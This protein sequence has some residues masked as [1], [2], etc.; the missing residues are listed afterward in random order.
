[1]TSGVLMLPTVE[2][3]EAASA[4]FGILAAY[5]SAQKPSTA[6]RMFQHGACLHFAPVSRNH[7]QTHRVLQQPYHDNIRKAA[8]PLSTLCTSGIPIN[9]A[10]EKAA[11]KQETPSREKSSAASATESAISR[12]D[13]TADC[14]K[15]A[16]FS[17]V[18][19]SIGC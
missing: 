2:N 1:M 9:P 3:S 18:F 16:V 19:L 4:G 5:N 14:S 10:L 8:S 15:R 6:L 17:A 11:L 12:A 13:A 7:E